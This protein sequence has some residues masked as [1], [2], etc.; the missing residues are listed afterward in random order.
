VGA[1]VV[2]GAVVGEVSVIGCVGSAVA[3]ALVGA[4]VVF[5]TAAVAVNSAA[6]AIAAV[7]A[8][9]T[10]AW[11]SFM[12]TSIRVRAEQ[13]S[14]AGR[15]AAA[16]RGAERLVDAM[17]GDR[18]QKAGGRGPGNGRQASARAKDDNS[19]SCLH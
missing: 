11:R 1:S 6:G 12:K 13:D 14:N 18:R 15:K 19:G 5:A 10:R 2:G 8:T 9:V 16:T 17:P 4:A 3:V 7:A